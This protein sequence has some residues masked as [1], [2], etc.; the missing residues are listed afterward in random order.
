MVNETSELDKTLEWAAS[1]SN[2]GSLILEEFISGEGVCVESFVINGQI[3]IVALL[4]RK[5]TPP[6]YCGQLGSA[7]PAFSLMILKNYSTRL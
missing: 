5:D 4:S 3:K 1:F 2:S 6:P 7:T